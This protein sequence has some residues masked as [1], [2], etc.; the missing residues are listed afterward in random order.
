MGNLFPVTFGFLPLGCFP[1]VLYG[2]DWSWS[3]G[4]DQ[5]IRSWALKGAIVIVSFSD[6]P[7]GQQR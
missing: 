4:W 1:A 6:F 3:W 5:P 2:R 7:F